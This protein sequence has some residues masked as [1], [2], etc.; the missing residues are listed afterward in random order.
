MQKGKRNNKEEREKEN[1]LKEKTKCAKEQDKNI[2]NKRRIGKKRHQSKDKMKR[3]IKNERG[4]EKKGKYTGN[5]R[6]TIIEK[7]KSD[8]T[9]KAKK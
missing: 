6:I 4:W 9:I 1:V 7:K 8:T 3:K 5:D 2:I